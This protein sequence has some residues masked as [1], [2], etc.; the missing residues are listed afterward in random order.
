MKFFDG[1]K[2]VLSGLINSRNSM[3]RS[4]VSHRYLSDEEMR[5]MYKAGLMSKIIRLKAGYAL[6]D[7]LKFESTQ[8]QEIYKKRL[9][10][11]VKNATKFMLGF[12][13]GVIIVFKN[14]DDLSQPLERGVNPKLLKIRVFSGDIAKGNNPNNDLRNERYYK[15]K[16][17]TIKG[18]T[19]HW[20]RVV[21]FTYYL[22]AESELPNYHYGGM[23]ESELIYEQFIN[24][25]IVQRASGSIIEKA[26]T[27]VYKIKGYKQLIQ[28]KKE[29]DVIQYVSTCEDG[30][31]I[32]GGLITDADDMVETLTQSLTDLDKVDNVT[33]RRIAMV[34]GLGMTVLIGE[35]ASGLNAS[36]EKERQGFQDTIENLQ[37]DYLEEPLNRLAEI[38]QLGFIEFKENQGQSANER[39]EYD[40]KAVDVA[41]ILW[42]LG[43]DY[44]AYLKDKD[45]VKV[46]DWD[47]F[48]KE[49]DENSEVDESLSLEDLFSESGGD[50][51]G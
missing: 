29:Q 12:G 31:S 3:A 7:T 15:P 30:R 45:V 24:D 19:V 39:V 11:H 32:Y 35:Q 43:E 8:D 42:E 26:S 40:K 21:D 20:T 14:G 33:L 50:I 28:S 17:Y 13:R 37:S 44:G 1:V 38:F 49:K 34:T 36:G 23:S 9:A 47:N 25:S 6:N 27:F 16:N 51:N 41:K 22:P 5:V 10:K 48:W 2:D 18:H 46:D 4:Q